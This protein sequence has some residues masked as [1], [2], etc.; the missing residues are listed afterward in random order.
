MAIVPETVVA[1]LILLGAGLMIAETVAPGAN[2]VVVGVGLLI[3][4]FIAFLLPF[5]S[6]IILPIVF[7]VVSAITFYFYKELAFSDDNTAQTTDASSL[8]YKEGIVTEKVTPTQGQVRITDDVSLM[9]S[10]FQARCDQGEIP[11]DTE[12]IVNNPGGGSILRV[13]PKDSSEYDKM[14]GLEKDTN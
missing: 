9:N 6:P 2:F 4:G 10:K 14:L 11:E 8:K 7:V 5:G 12:I 13:R 1:A 3:T